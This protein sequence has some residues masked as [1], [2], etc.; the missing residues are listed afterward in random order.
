MLYTIKKRGTITIRGIDL[1]VW[2]KI[3]TFEDR[4]LAKKECMLLQKNCSIQDMYRLVDHLG[5][6]Q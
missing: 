5:R 2:R 6:Y 1:P 3:A 4:Y